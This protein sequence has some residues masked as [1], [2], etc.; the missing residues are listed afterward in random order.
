M[1]MPEAEK[2][3]CRLKQYYPYRLVFIVEEAPGNFDAICDTTR[4]RVNKLVRN[5]AKAWEYKK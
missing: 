5:G 4:R 1:T 3:A 2:L